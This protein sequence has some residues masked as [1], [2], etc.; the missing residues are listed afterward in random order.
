VFKSK[1]DLAL[2]MI[3]AFPSQEELESTGYSN[4]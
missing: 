4:L 2:E 3:E 1:N